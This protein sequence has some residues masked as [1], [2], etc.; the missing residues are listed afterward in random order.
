MARIDGL[1]LLESRKVRLKRLH[2]KSVIKDDGEI[3][4]P[5]NVP[6]EQVADTLVELLRDLVPETVSAGNL[7][8]VRTSG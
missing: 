1:E 4:V 5:L 3:A 8:P 6:A 7:S 2:P